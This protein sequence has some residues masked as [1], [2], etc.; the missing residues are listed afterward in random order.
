VPLPTRLLLCVFSV[1]YCALRSRS[2]GEKIQPAK[3]KKKP[4]RQS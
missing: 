3:K 4:Q 2:G 1:V